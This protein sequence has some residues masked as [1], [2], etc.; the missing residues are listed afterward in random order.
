MSPGTITGT[1]GMTL[2][3]IPP[4]PVENL[5]KNHLKAHLPPVKM[6][7]RGRGVNPGIHATPAIAATACVMQAKAI[8]RNE[9]NRTL[10]IA[11][12]SEQWEQWQNAINKELTMLK[13]M[14]CYTE[15]PRN[16]PRGKQVLQSQRNQEKGSASRVRKPRETNPSGHICTYH[17]FKNN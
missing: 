15:T 12:K 16:I 1:L 3:D 13:D 7:T 4:H 10:T 5:H 14:E 2:F 11:R 9:S 17:Q 8:Q 6:T